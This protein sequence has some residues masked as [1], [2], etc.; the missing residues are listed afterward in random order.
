MRGS[1]EVAEDDGIGTVSE[2][3]RYMGLALGVWHR[4]QRFQNV[5]PAQ[6]AFEYSRIRGDGEARDILLD[7]QLGCRF[8]RGVGVG[9]HRVPAHDLMGPL[10]ERGSIPL[11]FRPGSNVGA[12]G[13]Q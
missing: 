3:C 7:H 9:G 12:E 8:D 6:N 2:G 13:F 10:V 11:G 1:G 5:F 4:Q